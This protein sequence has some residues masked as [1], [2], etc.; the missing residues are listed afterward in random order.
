MKKFVANYRDENDESGG[1][2]HCLEIPIQNY[3]E[4]W[5]TLIL[6]KIYLNGTKGDHNKK[7]KKND[8]LFEFTFYTS[9]HLG[10]LGEM[11]GLL[12]NG[13]LSKKNSFLI[14]SPVTATFKYR[15]DEFDYQ[16]FSL[17]SEFKQ[18]DTLVLLHT[19]KNKMKS[20]ISKQNM[21]LEKNIDQKNKLLEAKIRKLNE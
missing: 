8:P 15:G 6:T 1:I 13:L 21:N 16:N 2:L 9:K 7:I 18:G 19:F 11:I 4:D 10:V 5:H 14:T 12:F 3:Y 17:N 20:K